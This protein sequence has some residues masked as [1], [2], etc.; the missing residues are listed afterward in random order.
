M[1]DIPLAFTSGP[2]DPIRFDDGVGTWVEAVIDS[3]A[4]A[5]W[6][7]VTDINL[8]AKFSPEYQG[9]VWTSDERGLGASF[10]GRNEHDVIGTWEVESWI[11]AYEEGRQFGWGTSNRDSP[12]AQWT[13]HLDPD[14]DR[15]TRLR[16]ALTLGPGPSG[17][18]A[19]IK[20]MPDK[21]SRIIERRLAELHANMTAVV[22][23]I[24]AELEEAPDSG[25]A[26]TDGNTVD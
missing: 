7:A 21:E 16:Y 18:T 11:I 14:G 25:T 19:A 15:S 17:L 26:S 22:Q 5:V 1:T 3:P 20:N 2:S 24:R 12:G 10:I 23:G 9:G 13:F 6:A 8:P 4:D